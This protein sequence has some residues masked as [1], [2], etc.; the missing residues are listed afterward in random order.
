MCY[1]MNKTGSL[2]PIE[3]LKYELSK[4]VHSAG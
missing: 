4:K 1:S 3:L 2:W